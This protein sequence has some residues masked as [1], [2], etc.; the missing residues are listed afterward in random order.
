MYGT[1]FVNSIFNLMVDALAPIANSP[2]AA[3]RTMLL[4]PVFL[5]DGELGRLVRVLKC[6]LSLCTCKMGTRQTAQGLVMLLEPVYM[7]GRDLG[8][9]VRVW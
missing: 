8:R 7:Q 4:E 2:L 9:M 3:C 5:Q 1:A 6:C